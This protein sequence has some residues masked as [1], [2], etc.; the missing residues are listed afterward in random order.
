MPLCSKG[1]SNK[2]TLFHGHSLSLSFVA[3]LLN[4]VISSSTVDHDDI[5]D[6]DIEK[7]LE[8]DRAKQQTT[9]TTLEGT[10]GFRIVILFTFEIPDSVYSLPLFTL[11]TTPLSHFLKA[12]AS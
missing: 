7:G 8:A 12:G 6:D 2:S 10:I 1:Q 9:P 3:S 5:E 11:L 4:I